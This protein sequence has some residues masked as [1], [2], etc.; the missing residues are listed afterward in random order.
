MRKSL[1]FLVAATVVAMAFGGWRAT[2]SF[3]AGDLTL[4]ALAK[5][6]HFHGIAVDARDTSRLYLAT[7]H[8]L[9]VVGPDGRATPLSESRDDFMGFTAH[10]SDPLV[11]YASGH[12]ESGG[13]LGFIV[14]TDGGRTWT[15]LAAGVGGPV[16]FHQMDV[17]KADP[18]V[19]YGVYGD[20][21]R[22][23]DG[24]KTWSKIG[25]APEGLIGLAAS[26]KDASTLFAATQ[27]G[28]FKSTDAGK[29]WQLAHIVSKPATM[30]YVARTGEVYAFMAGTGLLRAKDESPNWEIVSTG[31]GEDVILHFAADPK[32]GKRLYAV[33]YNVQTKAQ[34]VVTSRDGGASWGKLGAQ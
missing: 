20:V 6:T 28:L 10:P 15:K 5:Q 1:R 26:S 12:P 27:K 8:G 7:H 34:A 18:K 31:F 11:L 17:S 21:Q 3:A 29:R 16:D 4:A 2:P 30:V 25:P 33:T 32:D 19:I 9:F 23:A 22:S 13:N 24:G 14:S